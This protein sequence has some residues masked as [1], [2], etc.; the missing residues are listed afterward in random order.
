MSEQIIL[1][2][3]G[4]K[5]ARIDSR[6]LAF[7]N[8]STVE[9]PAPPDAYDWSAKVPAWGMMANDRWGDCTCA[10]V[11]HQ[12]MSWN[13]DCGKIITF[14]DAET[15]ALY[16][17]ITG[18]DP[19]T[20]LN[21]NGANELDVLNYWRKTGF[22]GHM[23]G[24]YASLESSVLHAKQAI[25]LFGGAYLGIAMPTVWQGASSWT[26]PEGPMQGNNA[27]GSW[28]GHAVILVGY[29]ATYAY[30][31]TWGQIMKMTWDAYRFYVDE[32]YA[33]F[34]NDFVTG[35]KPAPN[36]FCMSDL[37]SDLAIITNA[38]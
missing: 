37:T 3:L 25:W 29:D 21:D 38:A 10:A 13:A 15:L 26:L 34:S 23:L 8:Y 7:G 28:G 5:A 36:G 31:V 27:P 18:F 17:A 32:A 4:K 14:S 2:K 33:L 11:A 19:A 30:V 22:N 1:P 16:S 35:D 9:L 12:V 24:A 20:G 6:T